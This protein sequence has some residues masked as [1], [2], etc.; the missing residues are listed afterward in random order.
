PVVEHGA[1]GTGTTRNGQTR[2]TRQTSRRTRGRR[3]AG[4]CPV[5]AEPDRPDRP[6]AR[7]LGCRSCA[8][9]RRPVGARGRRRMPPWWT[10]GTW[11]AYVLTSSPGA[12]TYGATPEDI[13]GHG[14]RR[15][16]AGV[17]PR[18]DT[19]LTRVGIGSHVL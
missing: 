4:L 9:L 13:E 15:S 18:G 5:R 7:P 1:S 14:F 11:P 19:R 6:G 10:W 3:A 8:A 2:Q 12:A 16:R 17:Q